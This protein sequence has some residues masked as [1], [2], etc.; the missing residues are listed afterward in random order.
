MTIRA[1]MRVNSIHDFGYSKTISLQ[2][3]YDNTIPEDQR[4]Q[5]ATPSGSITMQVDNPAA[6]A[7]FA[8]GKTFYLDFTE[9]P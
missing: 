5:K 6:A 9:V 1:K 3:E 4:F 7:R 8:V 2:C